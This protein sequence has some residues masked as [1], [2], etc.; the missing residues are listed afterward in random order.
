MSPPCDFINWGIPGTDE[1]PNKLRAGHGHLGPLLS[2][3]DCLKLLQSYWWMKTSQS[4]HPSPGGMVPSG[5]PEWP[6]GGYYGPT[7]SKT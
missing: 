2:R 4:D 3:F 6:T 7:S 5:M 1:I